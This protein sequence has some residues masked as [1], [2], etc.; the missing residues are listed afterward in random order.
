MSAVWDKLFGNF[1]PHANDEPQTAFGEEGDDPQA[2]MVSAEGVEQG[3][4]PY[5][6][7]KSQALSRTFDS[8]GRRNEALRAQLFAVESSFRD[9]EAI[10][11][12]FHETLVPID[13]T[14]IEIERTKTAH[15]DA[16]RKLEA[17]AATHDRLKTS[18]AS[19]TVERNALA[20]RQTELSGRVA[21]LERGIGVAEAASSEARA[22]LADRTATL[23]RIERDLEDNRRRLQAVTEQLPALRAEFAAKEKRLQEVEQQRAGL[24]DQNNLL[25]QENLAMKAR[26]EE[27]TVN[28]GKLGRKIGELES[29]REDLTRRSEE[30][31]TA[32]AQ[33]TVAHAKAKAAG[34]DAAEAQRLALTNLKEELGALGAR[35]GAAEKLLSEARETLRDREAAIRSYE[36]RALEHSLAAKAKDVAL[37]DFEKDIAALRG[38]QAEV[39][40]ARNAA[41]ERSIALSKA[42]DERESALRRAEQRI[43]ALEAR[44]AEQSRAMQVER[45]AFEQRAAKLKDQ[46]EAESAARAFA[47]GALQSARQDRGGRRPDGDGD[48]G[49]GDGWSL[50]AADGPAQERVARLHG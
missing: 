17:L 12:Q 9:I 46:L 4:Q 18:H 36:Q 43:E 23:E 48:A 45:E 1:Q 28:I 16:E 5:G 20:A 31:E 10:R 47:E 13:H 32:L 3:R 24:Q 6:P 22:A 26:I 37:A 15:A 50:Q 40:A 39:E 19:L 27:F 7:A 49:D 14:L 21:D 35:H 29:R 44:L 11:T 30:L 8:I 34:L 25:A 42:L 33:E 41:T 2:L 38:A